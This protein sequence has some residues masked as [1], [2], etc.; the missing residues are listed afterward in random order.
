MNRNSGSNVYHLENTVGY[1]EGWI[2]IGICIIG[3]GG[4]F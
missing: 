1:K 3:T 4:Y 2:L